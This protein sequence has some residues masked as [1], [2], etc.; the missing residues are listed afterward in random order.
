[1][2]N[3]IQYFETTQ[4]KTPTRGQFWQHNKDKKVYLLS[5]NN[6]TYNLVCLNDGFNWSDPDNTPEGVFDGQQ[7]DFTL[8][9]S[10][11]TVTPDTNN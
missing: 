7:Y 11:V 9:T 10:P 5:Q 1:M 2:N 3:K 6:D 8:I 4:T